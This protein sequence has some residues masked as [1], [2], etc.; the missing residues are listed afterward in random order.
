[1]I[2]YA[3]YADVP[4]DALAQFVE[5]ARISRLLTVGADG[6]PHIGL[7]PFVRTA[8]GFELHLHRDDEQIADLRE[9]PRCALEIDEV[10]SD[11]PSYWVHPEHAVFA[12]AYHKTVAFECTAALAHG[13]DELALQQSRIIAR[14]QPEGGHRPVRA[15]ES[16]YTGFLDMLVGVRL[17]VTA[18][19]VKFKIGQNRPFDIRARIIE[20]LRERGTDLDVRTAEALKWT[21]ELK[22]T[23]EGRGA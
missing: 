12:T 7:Y 20:R 13:R 10:L 5:S 9:R 15:D 6:T 16:M 17:G 1:M 11:I 18:T 21:I 19:K 3:Y 2:H 23:T 4:D 22:W 8:H 14:Y